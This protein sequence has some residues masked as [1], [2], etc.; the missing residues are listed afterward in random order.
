M[1]WALSIS[2]TSTPFSGRIVDLADKLADLRP[3]GTTSWRASWPRSPTSPRKWSMTRGRS[4][5]T[6]TASISAGSGCRAASSHSALARRPAKGDRHEPRPALPSGP[7]AK[8][9][10]RLA[11]RVDVVPEQLQRWFRSEVRDCWYVLVCSSIHDRPGAP[12][13]DL[14]EGRHARGGAAACGQRERRHRR[15]GRAA[16]TRQAARSVPGRQRCADALTAA[17]VE[18]DHVRPPL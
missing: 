4:A 11:S 12:A 5:V 8:L 3:G 7:R 17:G 2:A 15:D 6:L 13:G 10:T 9:R 14:D 1:T 18:A 16:R